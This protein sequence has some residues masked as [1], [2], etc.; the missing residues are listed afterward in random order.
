[1]RDSTIFKKLKVLTRHE[2][3]ESRTM[4]EKYL[5][6]YRLKEERME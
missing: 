3:E 2:V 1:M 5:T 6:C 4:T